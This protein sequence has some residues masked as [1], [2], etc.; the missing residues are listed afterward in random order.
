MLSF[1]LG[2]FTDEHTDESILGF[3]STMSPGQPPSVIFYYVGFIADNIHYQLTK[4]PTEGVFRYT[5]FLFH[6][7]LYFQGDNFLVTLK[8][9]DIEGNPMSVIFWT[10]LVRKACTDFTY[11][12]FSELF[13]H[14]VITMLNKAE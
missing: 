12:E 7:F 13:L 14:P 11:S 4:L 10:T 6:M 5:S 1:I 8:K 9:L 3:L 2:Y